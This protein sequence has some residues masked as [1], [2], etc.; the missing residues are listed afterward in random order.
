MPKRKRKRERKKRQMSAIKACGERAGGKLET[1]VA[2]NV[3]REGLDVE[4]FY[5]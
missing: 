2:G 1:L 4:I 5:D 3:Q